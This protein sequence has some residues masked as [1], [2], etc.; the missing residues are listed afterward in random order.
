M[1]TSWFQ[2]PNVHLHLYKTCSRMQIGAA[3]L[4]LVGI[5]PLACLSR[6]GKVPRVHPESADWTVYLEAHGPWTGLWLN[7]GGAT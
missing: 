6:F 2:K 4:L 5:Q 1:T 3:S 7:H